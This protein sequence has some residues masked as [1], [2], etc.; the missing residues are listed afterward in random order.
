MNEEELRED[1][2]NALSDFESIINDPRQETENNIVTF[3]EILTQIM[4]YAANTKRHTQHFLSYTRLLGELK[5]LATVYKGTGET[6]R[7]AVKNK[8]ANLYERALGA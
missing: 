1:V 7:A 8:L 5:T 2:F 3:N 6:E 4:L